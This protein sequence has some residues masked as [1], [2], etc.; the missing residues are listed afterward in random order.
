ML[1][2]SFLLVTNTQ[3]TNGVYSVGVFFYVFFEKQKYPNTYI[4]KFTKSP[5]LER[6]VTFPIIF[7]AQKKK[8]LILPRHFG[9]NRFGQRKRILRFVPHQWTCTFTNVKRGWR[10]KWLLSL[11]WLYFSMHSYTVEQSPIHYFF[12]TGVQA[13]LVE[14]RISLGGSAL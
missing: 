8:C 11:L 5:H 14:I 10:E 2:R 7:L 6:L 1:R 3:W 4:Q 12:F 13:Q 9:R